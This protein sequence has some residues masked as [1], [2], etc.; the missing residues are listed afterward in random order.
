MSDFKVQIKNARDERETGD[1]NKALEMFL[2]IDKSKLDTN[3]QLFDYLGELGLTY[4]HLKQYKEAK[5]TFEEALKLAEKL[6]HD[7]YKAVALRQLSRPELNEGNPDLAVQFAQEA[8]ELA[9][10]SK[11]QDIVWFDHGVVTALIFKKA[12]DEEIK[13]W[14]DL[15]AKD[16]YEISQYTSDEIAKWVWTCGLLI[17][18]SKVYDTISD[19][20]IALLIADNFNLARRREQIEKLISEFSKK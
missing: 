1:A 6:N 20:Y 13:N 15:E 16:L 4:W 9:F 8:R 5:E 17:D 19:L 18:R 2:Q 14:F 10:A 7:S 12:S 3:N 11:R